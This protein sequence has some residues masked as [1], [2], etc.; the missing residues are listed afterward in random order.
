MNQATDLTDSWIIISDLH[1]GGFDLL[2]NEV[3]IK[4]F[5]EV[6]NYAKVNTYNLIINGDL[7]DYYMEYSGTVPPIV[8]KGVSV[9]KDFLNSTKL[10][11]VYIT[12]NHDNW[13]DGYLESHG[14]S[15]VH[16]EFITTLGTKRVFIAHGDGLN[17]LSYGLPRPFLHRFLRNPAFIKIFKLITTVKTGNW[18]M[19]W[20]SRI[21]RRFDSDNAE[22][23]KRIDVW[24]AN[25]LESSSFDVVITA[26]H[27][28]SRFLKFK[29]KLYLNSGCFYKDRTAILYTK[30]GFKLVRWDNQTQTFIPIQQGNLE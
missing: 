25:M 29:N 27:H 24:A 1:L 17:D 5:A 21:N 2:T 20:F 22:T 12:G 3:L 6:V 10:P 9:L 15:V 16:E 28:H 7:F 18:I 30:N 19:K 4:E 26:H 13:D 8:E 11:V 14:L 23:T